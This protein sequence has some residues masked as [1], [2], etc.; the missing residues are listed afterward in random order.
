MASNEKNNS[1]PGKQLN[2]LYAITK[3][4]SQS[5]SINEITE[6]LAQQL[7][8][9]MDFKTAFVMRYNENEQTATLLAIYPRHELMYSAVKKLGLDI[10]NV[11]VPFRGDHNNVYAQLLEGKDWIGND[12]AEITTPFLPAAL[13]RMVQKLYDVKSIHNAPL[14][15]KGKLVGTI[16]VGS[17]REMITDEERAIVL[18]A[19]AQAAVA[20][21]NAQLYEE[22]QRQAL[23]SI[24]LMEVTN[25]I[26]STMNLR[27]LL[28]LIVEKVLQ[29]T[30]S[31]H[32]ALFLFDED[33]ETLRIHAS[34]GLSEETVRLVR[35]KKGES[36][37]GWVAQ[38]GQ[39]LCIHNVQTDPRLKKV[40]QIEHLHSMIVVP[41][42]VKGTV[43]GVLSVERL[44]GE[45]PFTENEFRIAQDFADQAALAIEKARI[46][47]AEQK[48]AL[49]LQTVLRLTEHITRILDPDRLLQHVVEML[50]RTFNYYAA[51]IGVVDTEK[52]E[53]SW[54]LGFVREHRL[55]DIKASL[56]FGEGVMGWVALHRKPLLVRNVTIDKQY[57]PLKELPETRAELCVP[58][59][60][61]QTV[62]AVL[63]VQ[64]DKVGAF[65]DDDV[66]M[67]QVIADHVAVAL[68]NAR[69]FEET[70]R[71]N[72]RLQKL[73]EL[74]VTLSGDTQSIFDR[75]VSIVAELLN[76]SIAIIEEVTDDSRLIRSMF[77]KG[78]VLHIGVSPLQ[79]TPCEGVRT[80]KKACQ[81]RSALMEFP[82]D[83]FL[84][85]HQIYTY[86]G[87]PILDR[88]NNVVGV[89]N[90]MD[91]EPRS[92]TEEDTALLYT[93]SDR[94]YF[95]LEEE[96]REKER[97]H[98]NAA[99][100]KSE[101]RFR[102]LVENMTEVYYVCDN[103]GRIVYG[104]P[105]LFSS[106]GYSREELLGHSYVRMIAR[107]DRRRI[108]DFYRER[109][110][111]GSVDTVCEFRARRKDGSTVWVE[112][113]TRIIRKEDGSVIEYRNVAR[114]TTKRKRAEEEAH[115]LLDV[116]LAVGTARDLSSGLSNVLR[117]VC[118]ATDWV[119]AQVWVPRS[120]GTVLELT[121]AWYT[122]ET[123][124]EKFRSASLSFTFPPGIGLPGRVW[125]SKQTAWILNVTE[126]GNFLR[127]PFAQESGL[128]AALG[129]PV[130]VRDDVVAVLEFFSRDVR[131]KD[132]RFVRL[133]SA[134]AAQFGSVIQRKLAE[135]NLQ[136]EQ[137]HRRVV[138]ENIFTF[139]PE[140]LL[141]F[142]NKLKLLKHNKAFEDIIRTYSTKLACTADKLV[143]QIIREV[144]ARVPGEQSGE[145]SIA[146]GQGSGQ[147]RQNLVLQFDMARIFLAEEEEEEEAACIVVS[148]RDITE[149]KR[150]EEKLQRHHQTIEA[151]SEVSKTLSSSLDLD[152]VLS[153]ILESLSTLF[154]CT[155]SAVLLYDS[156][157]NTLS[158]AA[159]QGYDRTLVNG[160]SINV[161]LEGITGLAVLERR[162][163]Y[164]PDVTKEPRYIKGKEG[165]R[166][167]LAL[168]LTVAGNLV[169]VLDVQD[170]AVDAYD[171]EKI[172]I[173][174]Q[175]AGFAAVAIE[176]AQLYEQLKASE[177]QYMELYDQAPDLYHSLDEEGTIILCNETEATVLGYTK[178]ELVGSPV[179]KIISP[180]CRESARTA[181]QEVLEKGFL[182]DYECR[183]VKKNGET[184]DVL[185][186][187]QSAVV[188]GKTRVVR[189]LM[190]DVTEKK[191]AELELLHFA[192]ALA[193][194]ADLVMITD[195]NGVIEYVNEAFER[196]T[197][198]TKEEMIGQTPKIIESG[199]HGS[200]FFQE[201]WS[202]LLAGKPFRGTLI[203]RKKNG[204][205]FYTEQT[206]TPITDSKGNIVNFVSV[207]RDITE[208]RLLEQQ[209]FQAQKMES[210]GTLVSGIAHDF[211][212][213]LN[214][215]SGFAHQLQKYTHDQAKVLKYSQTIEKSA[216]RGADLAA[217]LLTFVRQ[218]PREEAPTHLG[219]IINDIVLLAEET[220]PKNIT[221]Q[222]RV[223]EDLR[224]VMGNRGEFHQALLNICLNAR[225]AMPHGG[226]LLVEAQNLVVGEET[227]LTLI[228]AAGR[229][230]V[231][232]RIS[233][234]GIG[235]PESIRDK[236]FDPFFTTKERGKGTGLGLSI[237]YS[238][239]RNNKGTILVQSEEGKGST[240]QLYFPAIEERKIREGDSG[241]ADPEQGAGELILLVDDEQ[242]MQELGKEFLEEKGY[243]VLLANDGLEG[244]ELYRQRSNEIA[245]VILDLVMPK[246]DGGKTYLEMKKINPNVKAFFCSG[247]TSDPVISSLMAEEGLRALQKPFKPDE[248]IKTVREM[249]HA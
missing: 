34:R 176:N 120:D 53:V 121:P 46:Y 74:S 242:A 83:S 178:E 164:V 44:E 58:I 188:G 240:F 32:G 137:E 98:M 91:H 8:D 142:T 93:F 67:L 84:R 104:S 154:G 13:A 161:E 15:S 51:A 61:G 131:E 64:S 147:S 78:N 235:I 190:R 106:T 3:A 219:E 201:M 77:L 198:Y 57:I 230:C 218:R 225:D 220:F 228:T 155:S 113:S 40:T 26:N 24:S 12:F 16:V 126:D 191:K 212:N 182:H 27:E 233:D 59:R 30:D 224:P 118:E 42:L 101:Q 18:S 239:V 82:G 132:E 243:R 85:E 143:E 122:K 11:V 130:I 215:I 216:S 187:A 60:S 194:T 170:E 185:V 129:I 96:R 2:V 117:L 206:I 107:E 210:I 193:Q 90:V 169:G 33:N 80:Q 141:V 186:N 112:Q 138:V 6:I 232:V 249:L 52:N 41:L 99:L 207:G 222:K 70:Q 47:N 205:L 72:R 149:R 234:T 159:Q 20:I 133:I 165:V 180:D 179:A 184:L 65:S 105:N 1:G 97:E 172:E 202:M 166:S 75:I 79:G 81:Y 183:L 229:V 128:K 29:L 214:N 125:S 28:D 21:E 226:T 197:G 171:Q 87:V 71:R 92:F 156:N 116:T 43:R 140:G 63:D 23:H 50:Q 175:F 89:L 38:S 39:G 208:Q 9:Q 4:V 221:I 123:D 86:L 22:A 62:V 227:P 209:L 111:N 189:A 102:D 14:I 157:S 100:Q 158:I 168:P 5:L 139:V 56:K 144:K 36:I 114:D 237:V 203:N 152:F 115:L 160:L 199:K 145:I 181:F 236:I 135:E 73:Y 245:L 68:Q 192:N 35:F 163:I 108:V 153:K 49:Q 110:R 95:E 244:V 69:L 45:P 37:A 238:I 66:I 76:V 148:L 173:L 211:N 124:L 213:I 231:E 103:T 54:G 109:T 25:A 217:Q 248:F 55:L 146:K 136:K 31:K 10:N 177:K 151:L 241:E 246:M 195:K 127:A 19:A 134:V 7:V 88:Q 204:E 200:R 119:F 94:I 196:T 167:E 223:E 48:R 17:E 247:F 150:D 162:P 174:Q